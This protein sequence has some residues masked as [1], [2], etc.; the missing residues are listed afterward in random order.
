MRQPRI[1]T[2]GSMVAVA[3]AAILVGFGLCLISH[4]RTSAQITFA[5]EQTAV[6]DQMRRKPDRS[7]RRLPR[8]DYSR[9]IWRSISCESFV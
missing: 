6:F 5:D 9:S 2:W 4:I 3:V 8:Q 7:G 1:K